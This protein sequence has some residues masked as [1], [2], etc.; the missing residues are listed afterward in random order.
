MET[1]AE[2]GPGAFPTQPVFSLHPSGSKERKSHH[3]SSPS[4]SAAQQGMG[5]LWVGAMPTP[6]WGCDGNSTRPYFL[7]APL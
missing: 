6:S 4:T 5:G 2:S 3:F 1:E 7:P